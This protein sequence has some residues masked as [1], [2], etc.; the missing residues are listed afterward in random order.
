MKQSHWLLCV[1]KNSD[2]FR[3]IMPLSNLTRASLL[4]EWKLTAKAELSCEIYKSYRKCWKSRVSFCHQS[5]LVSRGAWMRPWILHELKKYA[6][7]TCDCCQPGRH[8]IRIWTERCASEGGKFVPSVV[9][10]SQISLK[11]CRG[12]LLA[13]MLLAVCGTL[14]AA[15]PWNGLE[16][17][18]QKARLCD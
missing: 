14:L 9:D 12:H 11:Y 8:L 7:K 10:D 1:A 6:R 16:H 3:K 13:V 5:S 2:W 4:V 17:S 15:V 18:H